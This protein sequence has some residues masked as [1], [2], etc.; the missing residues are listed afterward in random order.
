MNM[1]INW[2]QVIFNNILFMDYERIAP[3]IS[4]SYL[5]QMITKRTYGISA[6]E[7]L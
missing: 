4:T 1:A 2:N 7:N 6:S 5:P 3:D